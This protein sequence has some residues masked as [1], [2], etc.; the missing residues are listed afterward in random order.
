MAI[1]CSAETTITNQ[2]DATDL[3]MWYYATTLTTKPLSPSTTTASATPTGWSLIEPTITSVSDLSKYIYEC[4]QIVW[5]D[6]TCSWGDVQ[7]SASFEAAKQAYNLAHSTASIFTT[8]EQTH[9]KTLVDTVNESSSAITTLT[10]S[11]QYGGINLL[12]NTKSIDPLIVPYTNSNISL[13]SN[14]TPID[15]ESFYYCSGPKYFQIDFPTL[16]NNQKYT[17]SFDI[18]RSSDSRPVFVKIDGTET[19]IGTAATTWTRL[20]HTFTANASTTN[21]Q[22]RVAFD[23]TSSTATYIAAI[24]HI[25]LEQGSLATPWEYSSNDISILSNTVNTVSQTVDSNSSTISNLT[26]TLGTNANGTTKTDDIVHQVSDISQDLNGITTRVGKTEIALKGNY[27]VSSTAKG[28]ANKQATISPTLANYELVQGAAITVKFTTEN[29]A[30]N[31]TLN[32]NSTGA[33]PI[34]TYSG[35]ALSENEYKWDAG[36]TMTFVYDGTNW[37]IQD[38]TELT[39]IKNNET[40]INQTANNVLIKA[41]ESD[42][43]AAQGGQHL[44]QSLI[45]V[46]PNGIKISADKV[47]IEGAAI[48]SE[49]GY[50]SQD[51]INAINNESQTIYIQAVSGT[52]S[53]SGT[54][55]W[56]TNT[57]ESVTQDAANLTPV[58]TIKRPIYRTNYPV[59]FVATQYKTIDGTVTCTTPLKDDTIT[60]IDAG[61]ITTGTID[62][63]NITVTNLNADNITTGTINGQR[64]GVG[65]LSLDKLAEDVYTETEVD[66]IVDNLQTQI[67]GAIET[68]TGTNVPTL[69][70]TPAST[71]T[72]DSIKDTHVGDVYFVVNDQS[73]QNGYNYRF[74]K[75]IS[76]GTSTYSWQ[77][78][79]DNDVTNALQRLT[80]AEGKIGNIETFDS[81]VSSYMTN[82]DNEITSIKS[83]ATTLAGRVDTAEGTLVTK[84]D[85][86]TFNTLSQTVEGNTQSISSLS[87]ETTAITNKIT[88]DKPYQEVEWIEMTGKQILRTDW[89]PGVNGDFGFEA[90]YIIYN[91]FNTGSYPS[92][93][94]AT[95]EDNEAMI[96]VVF[97]V[98]GANS[99]VSK[100]YG[101]SYAYYALQT[102]S[103]NGFVFTGGQRLDAKMY[104]DKRRQQC[105]LLNG[106][107]TAPDGSTTELNAR[108]C[109]PSNAP[110]QIG[111]LYTAAGTSSLKF[112]A[113]SVVRIYSLKFYDDDNL[114]LNLV[115]ALRKSDGVGGLYDQVDGIFYPAIGVL[116]GEAIGDLGESPELLNEIISASPS[117]VD[118]RTRNSRLI[119]VQSDNIKKL[120]DGQ[121]I[122]LITKYATASETVA[123]AGI[124]NT[125]INPASTN[126]QYLRIIDSNGNMIHPHDIQIN[127]DSATALTTH[128]GAGVVLNLR[129]AMNMVY[130]TSST[131]RAWLCDANYNT[132]T[133]DNARYVQWY[134]NVLAKAAIRN[135]SIICGND[136]G[137][138]EIGN[139]VTFDL[140]YPLLWRTA[141][142]AINKTDY[143]YSYTLTYDR[144][145]ATCYPD[146]SGVKNQILYLVGE[147]SGGEFTIKSP[148]LTFDVP[149]EA[150]DLYYIPIGKLGNQSTGQNYL[151][152]STAPNPT[153]FA[154]IGD[155]FQQVQ[156]LVVRTANSL[157][158]TIDTVSEHTRKIGTLETTIETKADSS[159]VTTVSNRL[160]TVSDT[161]DSHTQSITSLNNT[162][163]TKADSS[164]VSALQTQTN[165]IS[166][167][168]DGHTQ[169]ISSINS[170]MATKADGSTV[171]TLSNQVNNISDTVDGHTSSISSLNTTVATKADSSTVTTLSNDYA[172]FKQQVTGFESTVG[173]TYA[174][175]TEVS[176]LSDDI[177]DLSDELDN[178]TSTLGYSI[179][180]SSD[181]TDLTVAN[182]SATL[183][184]KVYKD[185]EELTSADIALI[186]S[187]KWYKGSTLVGTGLT[188]SAN[189]KARYIARLEATINE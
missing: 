13:Y 106:V 59:L 91:D 146:I 78:I 92:L 15:G 76:N 150:D 64:I 4:L 72:T 122:T 169:S 8:F 70:N 129:Y 60:V 71:W 20:S 45:N 185:G 116:H 85:T 7:L 99:S 162:V 127:Y 189:Q 121:Q 149:T 151:I 144:T 163:A 27:A 153:M 166:D 43:T 67:D 138:Q 2:I 86:S 96:G 34:K 125:I 124:I 179:I 53:V 157:N 118:L 182:P 28:T 30:A 141:A 170:T 68:W 113:P 139:N 5:G 44:I 148:V 119:I 104:T 32:I 161:V 57:G 50:L 100:N 152:F 63:S 61:H 47:D 114:A 137:Y 107:Y 48:F 73:Q 174:T 175:K 31:P 41:T 177:S 140:S 36:S 136:S 46:A 97:G 42:T 101:P 62:A 183:T 75:T 23:S 108:D 160:N 55:T 11:H 39:R 95:R 38:S 37:C 26:Q 164:T 145:L 35:A 155:A 111:G 56:V 87:T 188:L 156:G 49:N 132:N 167:T 130:G 143:Q 65:S 159:T 117:L 51:N 40:L 98:R 25:K 83:A 74:T 105:S 133:N 9:N 17:L 126:T 134:N 58:W 186:G 79:K 21:A 6:G 82:T 10:E 54:T 109:R 94:T 80:T 84:V 69:N 18:S 112:E 168:V 128:Y 93:S 29:T 110:M 187:V 154:Y 24:R 135:A 180:V 52:S 88:F 172:T 115:P 158:E 1:K 178:R 14:Q 142:L 3:I 90:D 184:A 147:P 89:F 176:D 102:Y 22:I 66:N 123:A 103:P 81:T 165:T 181:V 131:A 77:L 120:Q 171:T 19:N 16:I 33:K 12:S 173:E